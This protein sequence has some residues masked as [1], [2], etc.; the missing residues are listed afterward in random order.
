MRQNS[1]GV[2]QN[3]VGIAEVSGER[4]W[5]AALNAENF[6]Q[7]MAGVIFH[8]PIEINCPVQAG[9]KKRRKLCYLISILM[10]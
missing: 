10:N 8:L 2:E 9:Q 4:A 1:A 3:F 5:T 7:S 6:N